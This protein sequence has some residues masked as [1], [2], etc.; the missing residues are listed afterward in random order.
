[1][2]YLG[3]QVED[4]FLLCLFMATTPPGAGLGV[5]ASLTVILSA[6]ELDRNEIKHCVLAPS[7][8]VSVNHP[9]ECG[10]SP[11][12]AYVPIVCWYSGPVVTLECV[13]LRAVGF[14][15]NGSEV[16]EDGGAAR[17]LG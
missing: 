7:L 16:G 17:R 11:P 13:N 5:S 12:S 1:M 2:K 15:K 3:I 6:H 10:T 14:M 9:R 4:I 8:P